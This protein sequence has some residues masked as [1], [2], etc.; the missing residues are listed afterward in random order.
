MADG[1]LKLSIALDE[2][3]QEL[4]IAELGERG[5][6]A[7]EQDDAV[8][9]AFAPWS[10]WS[11]ELHSFIERWLQNHDCPPEIDSER[12]PDQNWNA[13]WESSIEPVAAGRF[14]I[15]PS[16]IDA[17]DAGR[18]RIP[19]II[20]PKMSFG[21]GY[22]ASTRLVLRLLPEVISSRERVLDAGTGTGVLAI[23]A[24]KLGASSVFAFDHDRWSYLNAVEN[25]V[26][27]GVSATVE[28]AIGDIECVPLELFDVIL[29]NIQLNTI[30]E[31][32][33]AFVDRLNER[34][35]IVLSGLLLDQ[36][37]AIVRL[38]EKHGLEIYREAFETEWL[39]VQVAR[40]SV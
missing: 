22:H 32:L 10:V 28:V 29:A 23:A 31:M 38:A 3:H 40:R 17:D 30:G 33:P 26:R 19:I 15:R 18:D 36:R 12:M 2:A 16:W 9:R 11:V 4:L 39:A 13:E 5:F 20:D 1:T 8:L 21:T 24:V 34:G 6:V 37:D 35:S 14:V 7:F 25:V 27:N